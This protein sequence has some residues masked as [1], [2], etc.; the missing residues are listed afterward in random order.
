MGRE[1]AFSRC[2]AVILLL[3]GLAACQAEPQLNRYGY[4]AKLDP[5]P[6]KAAID[7]ADLQ[8]RIYVFADDS[9]EGRDA[10]R[11]GN[12][13]G[14][15]YIAGELE[16]LGIA[17]A[18]VNGTYFQELPYVVRKYEPTSALSVNGTALVWNEDFVAQPSGSPPRPIE[19][20]SILFGGMQGDTVNALTAEQVAGKL[21]VL[22]PGQGGR[23]GRGGGGR[24][25]GGRGGRGGRGGGAPNPLA[26]A[27]AV[28]VINLDDVGMSAR[29]YINNPAGSMN[30]RAPDAPPP[31]PS[32]AN[33]RLTTAAAAKLF[34]KPV[35]QLAKG[36]TGG[37]VSG[38]LDWVEQP[39]PQ[40]ARNVI[41]VIPGSDPDL[42]GQYV[43]IGAHNDHVGFNA[44]PV[45]HDSLRV[46]ASALLAQR[47]VGGE[48][49]AAT[50]EMRANISLNLDS[51]RAIRPAR[52]D[53]I[54]NGAD[55]DGS[56]SMAVLEIAEALAL[57]ETK[58]RRSILFVWHTGEEDGL[59]GAGYFTAN[60][61]VPRDSIVAQINI[62]MIG[63]G[64]A[65]DI[66]GGGDDYLAVVGS[67]RLSTELGQA[68]IEVNDRQ[69]EP[70]RLDYKFDETTE[71]SGYNNIYGRSDHA[72]YAQYGIPIAFFFTGLH[73]DYH[74]VTDEPEYIDYP[75]YAKIVNYIHDLTVD[76]ANR[77]RRPVVDVIQET[78][79]TGR[80]G[81]GGRGGG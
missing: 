34:G 52:L 77:D 72:R 58:P 62:D 10:G 59:L 61:T 21:V 41:A 26:S 4:P 13:K 1:Q 23:G 20:A 56:G 25:G 73:M 2:A 44:S 67:K 11:E 70:L 14:A 66:P 40:F 32:P 80:G 9:M 24:G 46:Y 51:L 35:D 64:R 68:V 48:L 39:V 78:E 81:R 36:E 3:G 37:A 31:E 8:T 63:R 5:R 19:G 69:P 28:A 71:W 76:V 16:R 75:H 65:E 6:T 12:M 30:N 42:A 45:D 7:V 43:A 60:P 57:A 18:G 49:E 29:S 50:D 55:D 47:I 74:Q 22:L 54:R 17:P 33:L 27:A 79:T 15:A 38:H 53:S